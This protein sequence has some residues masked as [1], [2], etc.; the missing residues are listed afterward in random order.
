MPKFS[1]VTQQLMEPG[2]LLK[3]TESSPFPHPTELLCHRPNEFVS[4][5][6]YNPL[7]DS[8]LYFMVKLKHRFY[9]PLKNDQA[10]CSLSV[11]LWP[12]AHGSCSLFSLY[13][14]VVICLPHKTVN[15]SR[16]R[17]CL[18]YLWNWNALSKFPS[19]IKTS[20]LFRR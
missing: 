17:G 4:F 12:D 2:F 8:Y 6:W 14:A 3:F 15:S 13:S 19:R 11:F 18:T 9:D 20:L 16:P 7:S 5:V 10:L 1:Q